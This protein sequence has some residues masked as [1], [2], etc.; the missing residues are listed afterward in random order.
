MSL[1]LPIIDISP[2]ASED[3]QQWQPVIKAIDEACR[4][5]GFFY[6]TG[7]G[8]PAEQFAKVQQMAAKLFALDETEKQKI[9]INKTPVLFIRVIV[10]NFIFFY[11]YKIM[12]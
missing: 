8:I 5:T 9:N 7:H 2:L 4:D 11:I 6:V 1:T 12:L 3:R 10:A